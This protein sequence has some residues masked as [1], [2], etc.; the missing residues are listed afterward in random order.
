VPEEI[1]GKL[2]LNVGSSTGEADDGARGDPP[3][4]FEIGDPVK[5]VPEEM[6]AEL[7]LNDGLSTGEGDNGARRGIER[8]SH[9]ASPKESVCTLLRHQL[10]DLGPVG[11]NYSEKG[12]LTQPKN[13][14]VA[15]RTCFGPVVFE[16]DMGLS[17]HVFK[18]VGV[19]VLVDVPLSNDSATDASDVEATS[20]GSSLNCD[21]VGS[22]VPDVVVS[23][24]GQMESYLKDSRHVL[25]APNALG[26]FEVEA[27]P[28]TKKLSLVEEVS[29]IVEL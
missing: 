14:W 9:V 5:S 28:V 8:I 20:V 23:G 7:G 24:G 18:G 2:G 25:L 21:S 27:S 15:S 22:E 11:A 4:A 16:K 1:W 6:R 10:A 17:N 3:L 26:D 12:I 13:S 19:S 29:S